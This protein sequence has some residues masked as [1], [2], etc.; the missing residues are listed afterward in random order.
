MA[1]S[2]LPLD[3]EDNEQ[4]I[5]GDSLASAPEHEDGTEATAFHH[6]RWAVF[7]QG[8]DD[9]NGSQIHA[10]YQAISYKQT[11]LSDTVPNVFDGEVHLI[12]RGPKSETDK[13]AADVEAIKA[14]LDAILAGKKPF[15]SYGL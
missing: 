10:F 2:F 15:N 12:A 5:D 7:H 1:T 11:D 6:G 8:A 3:H 14:D 4:N 9:G 13:V